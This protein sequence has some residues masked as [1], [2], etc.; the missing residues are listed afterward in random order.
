MMGSLLLRAAA[1]GFGFASSVSVGNECDISVGEVV[2]ALVDDP[3][4]RVILLFLETLRQSAVL[5][6]ALRRAR[7]AGKPVVAYKLGRSEQG[8]AL[9]QSHTGA[10]AGNDA[11]VDAFFRAHGVLRVQQLETLFEIVP[12]AARYRDVRAAATAAAP[13][14]TAAS[15][16]AASR[17]SLPN[18]GASATRAP[19]V[20][21]ITTTA[22]RRHG[23]RAIWACA[24]WSPRPR[25]PP[26][27]RTWRNAGCASAKHPSST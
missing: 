13:S 24:D 15:D 9:S 7:E 21:V 17:A 26:S 2:D 4:T 25:R 22:G 5:A 27:S 10:M 8:D 3:H 6:A 19:R 12:L 16:A 14:P 23:G 1:R 18:A 11:A 20:A